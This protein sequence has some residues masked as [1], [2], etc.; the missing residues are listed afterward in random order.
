MLQKRI[1]AI[2]ALFFLAFSFLQV[3]ASPGFLYTSDGS[4]PNSL[5]NKIVETSDGMIWIATENG[6]SCFNGSTFRTYYHDEKDSKSLASNFVRTLCADKRG[7][8]LVGTTKGIQMYHPLSDD[9]EV[10]E[11]KDS[12]EKDGMLNI[13]DIFFV[14]D[15][16]FLVTGNQNFSVF[17]DKNSKVTTKANKLSD[18]NKAVNSGMVDAKGNIWA[19]CLFDGVYKIDTKGRRTKICDAKG[20]AQLLDHIALGPDGQLYATG[21]LNGL[22]I[23]KG[24]SFELIPNTM[25][26]PLVRDIVV[27]PGKKALSLATDGN[28]VWQY[29]CTKKSL[30]Q[31]VVSDPFFDVSEQKIHSLCYSLDGDLWLACYQKGVYVNYI[32]SP[33]FNYIGSRSS[34]FNSIGKKC[35]TSM[36]QLHNG[37]LLVTTDNG[38]IYGITPDGMPANMF[39]GGKSVIYA[40]KTGMSDGGAPMSPLGLFE[41]SRNRVWFGSYGSGC[42][43]IDLASGRCNYLPVKDLAA[44]ASVYA[45]CEDK[46]GTIWAASMG[47]GLMR[48]DES[49]KQMVVASMASYLPWS[50]AIYYD[51]NFDCLYVGTYGALEV[52]PL[53]N[54]N[55][56]KNIKH[57]CQNTVI[58]SISP[59]SKDCIVVATDNGLRVVNMRTNREVANEKLANYA[60]AAVYAALQTGNDGLWITTDKGLTYLGKEDV[61]F[62]VHDGIQGNEFYK[63]SVLRT[64]DG[65]FYFGGLNGITWFNPSEIKYIS[66]NCTVRIV[67]VK[68]GSRDY[69]APDEDGNYCLR[70]GEQ[71]FV[72]EMVTSPLA[73]THRVRYSYRLDGT[74]WHDLPSGLNSVSFDVL[75]PGKHKVEVRAI[76]DHYISDITTTSIYIE[77]PWYRTWWAWIIWWLIIA[78]VAYL[79]R[80]QYLI[81][82]EE[83]RRVQE[84]KLAEEAQEERLQFFINIAHD[85][86]T[87]M[88]LIST[89]LQKLMLTD[90]DPIRQ[91]I[92]EMMKRNSD[93]ILNLVNQLM[94]IRKI[95]RGKMR[96]QCGKI[97]FSDFIRNIVVSVSDLTATKSQH[98]TLEPG[99]CAEKYGWLDSDFLE[100]ILLNLLGN[101]VK[102]TPDGGHIKVGWHTEHMVLEVDEHSLS[103]PQNVLVLTVSDTGIGIPKEAQKYIFGRFYQVMGANQMAKGT[104]IGLNLVHSLVTLHHGKVEV[105]SDVDGKGTTFTVYLPISEGV[106]TDEEKKTSTPDGV[107]QLVEDSTV[108][109]HDVQSAELDVDA[110]EEQAALPD[111]VFPGRFQSS[112]TVS[113]LLI[114]DD[115]DDICSYLAEEFSEFYR[116]V[117]ASDGVQALSVLQRERVDLII[118]DIMMPNM[119]GMELCRNIRRNVLFS[120][121]PIIMLTAKSTD[122]ERM[123]SLELNV[124]AFVAKP[125]NII[126]LK[127]SIASL[128]RRHNQLRNT[129]SGNQMPTEKIDTPDVKSPDE[130][131]LQRVI[132]VI[133]DNLSNPDITSEDIAREVGLSRVH[134]YRKLLEL[135]N[136]TASNYIRNIRLTKGAEL[137]QNKKMSISEVAY[138]VGFKTPNHFATAFKKMYGMTPSEFM[139]K[140]EEEGN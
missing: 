68:S 44:R 24:N 101:S 14:K 86:R 70:S 81:R 110:N 134:L 107:P 48:Y 33:R 78:A 32:N 89:P 20:N 119:D 56:F 140:N 122:R 57:L 96:L 92:Y 82:R 54:P 79:I 128:L 118:T 37:N 12:K 62:N 25:N 39:A 64:K 135:T 27:V 125:F 30:E 43:N 114:V 2:I 5:V 77:Y 120:H 116:V 34:Q 103:A 3:K 138:K 73:L 85:L 98:L 127:S 41:D 55:P 124:D 87:P 51:K 53:S 59:Y 6:L 99:E 75:P 61:S 74:E 49:A 13:S 93:R 80:R 130:R 9:F 52:I 108:D 10:I 100:K 46:R 129:F 137:L 16:E 65:A 29:D 88:T 133:N 109:E 42:G 23:F 91:R 136:Q 15:G 139:K 50:C 22:Y 38:G 35:V 94:D 60:N 123:E 115:E 121:L 83:K 126:L 71:F 31:I 18:L 95:D 105:V 11:F 67:G 26:L 19:V 84:A 76:T 102:Y 113:T 132:K 106:Y 21:M 112:T 45:F 58:N 117:T 17:L 72:L 63:N 1:L 104:G 47:N 28:G 69:I 111:Y 66:K 131:L 97:D 40:S 8:L 36:V 4:L 7:N 90:E